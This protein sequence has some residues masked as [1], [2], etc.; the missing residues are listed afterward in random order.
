MNN[1]R[2]FPH[3]LRKNKNIKIKEIVSTVSQWPFQNKHLLLEDIA[4]FEKGIGDSISSWEV[5]V[6][7]EVETSRSS[8]E[9]V[10]KVETSRSSGEVVLEKW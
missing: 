5:V 7:K 6:E 1:N 2:H 8:G 9:A 10:V 4:E 3:K